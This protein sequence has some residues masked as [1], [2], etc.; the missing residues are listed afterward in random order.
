MSGKPPTP[1]DNSPLIGPDQ[2]GRPSGF[3]AFFARH[4]VAPN[5]VM[6]LMILGGLFAVSRMNVQF[7]PNFA[8]DIVTVSV[9]WSGAS[10]A[11]VEQ[12][13]TDPLEE[14][15]RSVADVKKLTST[16]AQGIST[17]TIEFNS[18]TDP[19]MALDDVRQQ[20][21]GFRNLPADAEKPQIGRIARFDPVARVL[22]YG[23]VSRAS[24]RH[25]TDQFKTD[26][27]RRGIDRI[28]ITGLPK[29]QISIT[30]PADELNQINRSLPQ[31]SDRIGAMSRD[32]PAGML[33][34]NDG[35]RGLRATE[36]GRTPL[37]FLGLPLSVNEQNHITVGDIAGV[38]REDRRGGTLLTYEGQPAVELNLQR[39]EKGNSLVAARTLEQWLQDTRATLPAGL[40][41]K[42]YDESWRLIADRIHLLISNAI[43]GLAIVMLLLYLFLPGRVA[44]WVAVG[45]PSAFLAALSVLWLIGGSINMMSLFA[46]IMALGV[47]VDDAIVVGEDADAHYRAGEIPSQ[48]SI[49]AA[50]RMFWPVIASS[51]TTVAAFMPLLAVGGII[52][53][54]MI[55]IPIVMIAV[56]LASLLECF[57]VLPGHLRHAFSPQTASRNILARI[58]DR[59]NERF[60]RFRQGTFRQAVRWSLAHRAATL[61]GAL[62]SVI[63]VAGLM[64]GGRIGFTFFP[65]PE[66]QVLYANALFVAGT[67]RSEMTGF[68]NRVE[69]ALNQTN[70]DLGGG[71]IQTA[72]VREGST[73]L[74][75]G[76]GAKGD[77]LGSMMVELTP[78][79]ARTIRNAEF[80]QHWKSLIA[81]P[82]GMENF[83]I[84][85]RQSGP[86]GAD[87]T[88]QLSGENPKQLKA[89]ALALQNTLKTIPGIIDTQDDLPYGREQLI[90]SVNADGQALGLTTADVGQ[91]LRAAFD[92][93]LVQIYQQDADEIEVRVL[94]PEA[95]RQTLAGLDSLSIRVPSGR[96][97][98]LEQVVSFTSQQ[99]FEALRHAHGRL[100]VEVTADVDRNINSAQN[101]L[102]ALKVKA[103]PDLA[104]QYGIHFSLE[105]RQADQRQTMNDMK[106]GLYLG[107]AL[108]YIVLV[109]VFSAWFT[110]LIVMLIIPFGLVGAIFGHWIMGLDLT[111]LSM[112]GLFGLSGIVVNNAIIL[113]EFYRSARARGMNVAQALEEA[114]TQRLRAVLLTSLTTIGGLMPLMFETSLQAQFLI[115]MATSLSFGLAY[116]TLL[117]LF[118]IP[119]LLSLLEGAR[120]IFTQ[121]L[122]PSPTAH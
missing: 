79:D 112:F 30:V 37:D 95:E 22:V 87:L 21:D 60:E 99:G 70:R 48:A 71:L 19:I 100:T 13:I 110:P 111:V 114:S 117:V 46:L 55:D 51:M 27:M 44:L 17:I 7:F 93:Q 54:I 52:G 75:A 45:I 2:A 72:L 59:F 85:A 73:I 25:W 32:F 41:I 24:L 11:D 14:R 18:G 84:A 98:P 1:P 90:F 28:D 35:G 4:K 47:I 115:P 65:T 23:D 82:P 61:A 53:K 29:Q 6:L 118:I 64:A 31:L 16:S 50:R 102:D 108:M 119:T 40:H 43:G 49:G 8:L 116:A 121:R 91:Q 68:I 67:P 83:S 66:P 92:G 9:T 63:L 20:V 113:V 120:Q 57:L 105:G 42:T 76:G 86:P 33:G 81:L 15:L 106:F 104:K 122:Q 34:D 36:Q 88:V 12:A 89:A 97:V 78:P 38:T 58:R 96:F 39:A 107:L 74:S 26:L 109:W 10:S 62:A 101:I 80:I 94:L 3:L 77:Q 103:L 56:I 69:Q 5:L